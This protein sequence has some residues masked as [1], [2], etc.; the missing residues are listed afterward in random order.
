MDSVEG[1]AL[2]EAWPWSVGVRLSGLSV[3]GFLSIERQ[4]WILDGLAELCP[5]SFEFL[6]RK[7]SFVAFLLWADFAPN[8]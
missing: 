3:I 4:N 8:S 6:D 7:V 2:V 5:W 1:G